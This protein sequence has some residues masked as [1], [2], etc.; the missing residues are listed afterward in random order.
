LKELEL[1]NTKV[2]SAGLKHLSS[3]KTLTDLNLCED[4]IS[5]DGLKHLSSLANLENLSLTDAKGVTG[6]GL[7][8]LAGLTKLQRLRLNG[9]SVTDEGLAHL[10]TLRTLI[11]VELTGTKVSDDAALELKRALP[12]ALIEDAAG[13]DVSLKDKE[14][15]PRRKV[16]DL[17]KVPPDFS[18]TAEKFVAEYKEN[19]PAA[20][21]KYKGKVVQL[22]GTVRFFSENSYGPIVSLTAGKEAFGAVC[23]TANEEPWALAVPGQEVKLKGRMTPSGFGDEPLLMDCVLV[24]PAPTQAIGTTAE[25]LAQ[26][27]ATDPEA[28]AK[29]YHEKYLIVSGEI[30]SKDVNG[31][32]RVTI[33]LKGDGKTAISCLIDAVA[34]PTARKLKVGQ[35]LKMYGQYSGMGTGTDKAVK[36]NSCR[37]IK[38]R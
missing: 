12:N 31:F 28:A 22:T 4:A 37:P 20:D 2:T 7:K 10:K 15:E 16:E 24:D 13:Q 21:Q 30:E 23:F 34:D 18:M 27:H 19:R 6:A 25:A 8:H 3:L 1:Q 9:T 14:A 33:V 36:L 17:I 32:G 35:K 38:A 11:L 29:K 26:E 5:D